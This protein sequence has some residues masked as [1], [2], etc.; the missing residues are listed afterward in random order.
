LK[1]EETEKLREVLLGISR[2]YYRRFMSAQ[3]VYPCKADYTK[4]ILSADL[5]NLIG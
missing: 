2:T 5:T 3:R 4:F 1:P